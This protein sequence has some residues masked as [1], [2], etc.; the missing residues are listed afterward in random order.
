VTN[1][2]VLEA[3]AASLAADGE[4][5][6]TLEDEGRTLLHTGGWDWCIEPI[7]PLS[8]ISDSFRGQLYEATPDVHTTGG[9]G[10]RSRLFA[11]VDGR[12]L[13]L[14]V[15]DDMQWF[16]AHCASWQD[17]ADL[18]VLLERGQGTG[19]VANVYR[20]DGWLEKQIDDPSRTLL[21]QLGVSAPAIHG[22]RLTFYAW[23]I[24]MQGAMESVEVERWTLSRG[25]PDAPEWQRTPLPGRL[26]FR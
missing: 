9:G 7:A 21:E 20:A 26:R 22:D 16:L 10:L 8:A 15:N 24:V 17:P 18:A 6:W 4:V 2:K 14:D 1:K 23:R 19:R 5:R 25:H 13:S 12:V 11:M 3:I